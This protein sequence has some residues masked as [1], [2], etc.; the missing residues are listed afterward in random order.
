M[1]RLDYIIKRLKKIYSKLDAERKADM[2]VGLDRL[3]DSF[4]LKWDVVLLVEEIWMTANH[5]KQFKNQKNT[6]KKSRT[7][8]AWVATTGDPFWST[9]SVEELERVVVEK[10][11]QRKMW[12]E[13]IDTLNAKTHYLLADVENIKLEMANRA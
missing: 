9:L 6:V 11:T 4:D 3:I 7:K 12:A 10:E 1:N 2:E 8:K 13:E 5:I